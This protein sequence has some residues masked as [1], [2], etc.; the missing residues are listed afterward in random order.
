MS[1]SI[2]Q[3]MTS[4]YAEE[5]GKKVADMIDQE[6]KD[7]LERNGIVWANNL[8]QLKK[9]LDAA[10]ATIELESSDFDFMSNEKAYKIRLIKTVDS[11]TFKFTYKMLMENE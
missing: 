10:Q 1:N 3:A 9:N 6:A 11:S 5:M 7:L 8:V 2:V 4:Y